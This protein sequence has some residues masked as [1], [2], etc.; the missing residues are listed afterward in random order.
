MGTACHV[1][2]AP[3]VKKRVEAALGI[4]PGET[5]ADR[6]FTLETVNCM[7]ACALGPIVVGDG[8]YFSSVSP[9]GV[10]DIIARTREGQDRFDNGSDVRVFPLK[11]NCPRCNHTLMDPAH[12]IDGHPSIRLTVSFAHKHGWLRLSSL[13]G[14]HSHESEHDVPE[15]SL[16]NIFCPHCHTELNGASHCPECTAAMVPLIIRSGGIV[17]I[18]PRKGCKGHL[19]DIG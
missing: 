13:Y 17:Q 7:G 19:L 10:D 8:R 16:L 9:S 5:T 15:D 1:R 14:S 2:G 12:S 6:E 18:C 11:V 4:A 3:A